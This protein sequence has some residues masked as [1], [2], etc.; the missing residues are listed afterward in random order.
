MSLWDITSQTFGY[1]W[2][3]NITTP[4]ECQTHIFSLFCLVCFVHSSLL[5]PGHKA[6]QGHRAQ[7][8]RHWGRVGGLACLSKATR[9]VVGGLEEGGPINLPE[10]VCESLRDRV[11]QAAAR[12]HLSTEELLSGFFSTTSTSCFCPS[13]ETATRVPA[14]GNRA[15]WSPLME[16][17]WLLCPLSN[18]GSALQGRL[19]NPKHH[20]APGGDERRAAHFPLATIT[21]YFRAEM[22]HNNTERPLCTYK[23]WRP[24]F[25]AHVI[26]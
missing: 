11:S 14:S 17:V 10:L 2:Q 4:T 13:S 25:S 23:D 6:A 22:C 19:C 16:D 9:R 5:L 24:I 26:L 21:G 18:L 7:R 8:R 20:R 3:K 15:L 1:K 12:G